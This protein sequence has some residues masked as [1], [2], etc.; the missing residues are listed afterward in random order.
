MVSYLKSMYG[1]AATK[2]N[3]FGYDWHPRISGHHSHMPMI[4]AMADGC[5]EG[6]F[7]VG[8]NPATSI[9]SRL[10]RTALAQLEWL[11]VKGNFE[12]ETAAFW[13]AAP[14]V[15]SGKLKPEEIKTEVFLFPSAQ[16]GEMAG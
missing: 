10:Q 5:V 9:N 2:E 6:M 11:V 8:Q 4:V 16:V 12:T 14:E 13:Y 7:A 15:K 1:A 3:Q